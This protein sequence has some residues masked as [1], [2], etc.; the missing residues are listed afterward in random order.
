MKQEAKDAVQTLQRLITAFIKHRGHYKKAHDAL[1]L[2]N[3]EI[4]RLDRPQPIRK[5]PRA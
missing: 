4:E 2:L 1:Q 5:K 3:K